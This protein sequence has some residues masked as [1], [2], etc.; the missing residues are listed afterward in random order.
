MTQKSKKREKIGVG[1]Q[2]KSPFRLEL[3]GSRGRMNLSLSG[4]N[5]VRDYS[6]EQIL[7]RLRGFFIKILG[8]G[9]RLFIFEDG[10]ISLEGKIL[11]VE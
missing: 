7:L 3:D 5:S 1:K 2:I 11:S 9:L 8:E 4:V 10:S 6:E